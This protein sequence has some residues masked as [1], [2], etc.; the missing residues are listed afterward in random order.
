MARL[1]EFSAR[2][3]WPVLFLAAVLSA[4]SFWASLN[5]PVYTS[6]QALLPQNTDV[7][8]RFN[9]FLNKFGAASDLIVVVEGENQPELET[10]ASELAGRLRKEPEIGSASERIDLSFF[11]E[12]AYLSMPKEQLVQLQELAG[13]RGDSAFPDNSKSLEKSLRS[14][15]AA[16]DAPPPKDQT[17]LK[18]A[19]QGLKLANWLVGEWQRWLAASDTPQ[20]IDFSPLLR[21]YGAEGLEKG[22]FTSRDGRMLFLFV[23]PASS[24]GEFKDRAPFIEKVRKVADTQSQDYQSRGLSAPKVAFTGLPAVEYE[25]YIDVEK[26]ITFVVSTAAIL[27]IL[28]ILLVVRSI[29]WALIIFI[30]MGLGALWGLGLAFLTVGHLTIITSGFLAILFG[31]GVDY[32]I[33]TSSRIAEERQAGKPLIEAI[34]SGI[35]S[36]FI[37]VL[38][39]GGASVLIFGALTTVDFPGFSELGRVAAGGVVLIL[40]STWL[41]QPALYALLPPVLKDQHLADTPGSFGKR[42]SGFFPKPLAVLLV[43]TA[44]VTATLGAYKGFGMPFDY[45]VLS[46]LPEDSEAAT[47]QRR[48]VSESEYQ[49]EVIIFTANTME[50]A[51]RITDEAGK[52]KSIAKVQSITSLFPEDA[53]ERLGMARN[54]GDQSRKSGIENKFDNLILAGLTPANFELL[55][56]LL[57]KSLARIDDYQEQAFS[58]GHADLVASFEELRGKIEKLL[59]SIHRNQELSQTR[60]ESFFK[61][62]LSSGR[63]GLEIAKKW[64]TQQPLTPLEIPDSLR[65]RFFASDGTIAVYAFPRESV[66]QRDNLVRLTSDVYSVSKSATGF[67]TTHLD[68]SDMVVE[69]FTHGTILALA[70]CLIFLLVV[71]RNATG[72]LLA[73]MPL[74]IGGGWMLGILYLKGIKYNYA[75]IIALPLVIALAVDYGVWFSHRWRDLKTASPLAVTFTAGRV[76]LLAAGTELAGLGAIALARYRGVSSLGIDITIGLLC[77]LPAT[78]LVGPAIGQLL[79]S[80]NRK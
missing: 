78:L 65:S 69:S 5:L 52:L 80:K 37:A 21:E 45:D 58:A 76:I 8:H 61:A 4:L 3:P 30:P 49:S 57:N 24:S 29:R 50:E 72:F 74:L 43:A 22:Y 42:F 64:Q 70:V 47:Y 33:F 55:Q 40:L 9:D 79:N 66:Y 77:C 11:L 20:K 44:I 31:L 25:E 62:L 68:F 19:N 39:S 73:A 34:G 46:L 14:G 35:G 38:T 18:Q 56:K 13:S 63:D 16:F 53:D 27:I 26:D 54:L 17:D 2:H 51:R 60:S 28:L 12:H 41:V 7:A 15:L 59:A 75:N 71:L 23:H 6:R 32:G 67:P 36:S 10:Y 48:M 1:A